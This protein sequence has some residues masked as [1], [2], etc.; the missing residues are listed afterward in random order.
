MKS[1]NWTLRFDWK[2]TYTRSVKVFKERK[3]K[4][5]K[6]Y[7]NCTWKNFNEDFPN[8]SE[9]E[10]VY[11]HLFNMTS[12]DIFENWNHYCSK[13]SNEKMRVCHEIF[14]LMK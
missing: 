4:F 13:I 5:K 2:E 12:I 10:S 7:K 1:C 3:N 9:R 11:K 8:S 14:E 6:E